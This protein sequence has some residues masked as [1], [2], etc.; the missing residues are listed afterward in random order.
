MASHNESDVTVKTI[1]ISCATC[2]ILKP[3]SMEGQ[4]TRVPILFICSP[5]ISVVIRP[6]KRETY[7]TLIY[8]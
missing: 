4:Q 3:V 7:P 1:L 5:C 6:Q 8:F 2:M